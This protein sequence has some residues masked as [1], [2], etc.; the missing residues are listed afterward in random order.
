MSSGYCTLA[1]AVHAHLRGGNKVDF[2]FAYL[3]WQWV[4]VVIMP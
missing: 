2:S 1:G 3:L 4:R